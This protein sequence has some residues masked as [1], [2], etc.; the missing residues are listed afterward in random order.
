M[1]RHGHNLIYKILP[2]R[3]RAHDGHIADQH[4]VELRD[5]V[6][7]DLAHPAAEFGDALVVLAGK[8]RAAFFGIGLHGT[9]LIDAER[10]PMETDSFVTVKKRSAGSQ[11]NTQGGKNIERGETEKHKKGDKNIE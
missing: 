2:F 5:F 11:L 10:F 6:Q 3:A 4:I 9:E 8:A 1:R 7:P